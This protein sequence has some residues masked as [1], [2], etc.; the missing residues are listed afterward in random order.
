MKTAEKKIDLTGFPVEVLKFYRGNTL[1]C[2]MYTIKD[3]DREKEYFTY[4]GDEDV[5][6]WG[7]ISRHVHTRISSGEGMVLYDK[8]ITSGKFITENGE[9]FIKKNPSKLWDKYGVEEV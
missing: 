5:H 9:V 3:I 4:S 2:T 7:I 6:A 1:V 8:Y